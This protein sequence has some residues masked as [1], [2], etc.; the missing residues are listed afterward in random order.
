VGGR[1][2]PG[3]GQVERTAKVHGLEDERPRGGEDEAIEDE[4]IEGSR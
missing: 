2:T 3:R 1:L 4:V